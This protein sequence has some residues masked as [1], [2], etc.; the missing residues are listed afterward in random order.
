MEEKDIRLKKGISFEY[1]Q[2]NKFPVSETHLRSKLVNFLG[3]TI[4]YINS[5]N[6]DYKLRA[7]SKKDF[8]LY[9]EKLIKVDKNE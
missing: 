5:G 6:E 2:Y 8:V 9:L 1:L 4:L 7:N 3:K